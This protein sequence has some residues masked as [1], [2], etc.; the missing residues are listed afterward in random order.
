MEGDFPP[1]AYERGCRRLHRD[2]CACPYELHDHKY[3][4]LLVHSHALGMYYTVLLETAHCMF[5]MLCMQVRL[6]HKSLVVHEWMLCPCRGASRP[7]AEEEVMCVKT[8]RHCLSRSRSGVVLLFLLQLNVLT[9]SV[10]L[11]L[12]SFSRLDQR[13]AW[14]E[15]LVRWGTMSPLLII[16][17]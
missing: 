11:F 8:N 4:S 3:S 1:F 7:S 17:P 2:L 12:T 10:R 5:A 16:H 9:Q 6:F 14:T 15:A 13:S